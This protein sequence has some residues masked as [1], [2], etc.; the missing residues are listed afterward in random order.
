MCVCT[1][2]ALEYTQTRTRIHF[3]VLL[4]VVEQYFIYT[5]FIIVASFTSIIITVYQIHAQEVRLRKVVHATGEVRVVRAGGQATVIGSDEV[6]SICDR[7]LLFR[8]AC[9]VRSY[10]DHER[11]ND[12]AM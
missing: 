6:C 11:A 5:V 12:F 9:A 2:L 4:F 10:R 8:S 7:Y 1:L 3:S